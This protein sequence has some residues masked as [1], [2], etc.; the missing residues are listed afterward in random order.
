[1]TIPLPRGRDGHDDARGVRRLPLLPL[2]QGYYRLNRTLPVVPFV[3]S[4]PTELFRRSNKPALS[5]LFHEINPGRGTTDI[6]ERDS[7]IFIKDF[8]GNNNGRGRS[9]VEI[10]EDDWVK[11]QEFYHSRKLKRKP[12]KIE[13]KVKLKQVHENK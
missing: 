6:N 4:H 3:S 11:F 12:E 13:H 10:S 5:T 9:I 1:M 2:V 8:L 7:I